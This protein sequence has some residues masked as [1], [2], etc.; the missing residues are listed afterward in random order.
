VTNV[1]AIER[2]D[3]DGVRDLSLRT[4]KLGVVSVYVTADPRHDTHRQALAIDLRNRFRQLQHRVAEDGDSERSRD[5]TATLERLWRHIESLAG[6]T[7][8]AEAASPSP[9]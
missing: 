8:R 7:R 2:L 5:V 1:V 4:D 9:R 6:P 3:Q